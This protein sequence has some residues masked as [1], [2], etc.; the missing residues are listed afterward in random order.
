MYVFL[1]VLIQENVE[2][3]ITTKAGITTNIYES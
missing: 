1:N 2:G 3:D